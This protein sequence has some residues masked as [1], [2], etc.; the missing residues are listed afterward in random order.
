MKAGV[1]AEKF[2]PGVIHWMFLVSGLLGLFF[3]FLGFRGLNEPDEGRY[4]NIA[5]EMLEGEHS[6]LD[7]QMSDLGHYDKPPVIYWVAAGFFRI[8]GMNEW[9]ARLPS[10]LGAVCALIGLGWT[11]WRLYGNRCAWWSVLMAGTMVH[12]WVM[13]RMLTPDMLLAG[14]CS[15]AVGA[16]AETRHR[17]GAWGPWV[18]QLLFWTLGWWTK[19]SPMLIPLLGL[20]LYTCFWGGPRERQ[21][22]K[23]MILVPL[24]LVLG[25]PWFLYIVKIHPELKEF[26]LH[27]E[28]AGRITGHVDGRHG[29]VYFYFLTS[30]VSWLPWWP[31]ALVSAIARLRETGWRM[32]RL[33]KNGWVASPEVIIVVT[34]LLVFSLISSKLQTYTLTLAPWV[35]LV[36]ARVWLLRPVV[37]LRAVAV[38]AGSMVVLYTSASLMAPRMETSLGRNSS[39]K[40]VSRYLQSH[41]AVSVH[42]DRYWPGLEFYWDEDVTYHGVKAPMEIASDAGKQARHFESPPGWASEP[43]A[44]FIHF[45]KQ[46]G[47]PFRAWLDDP[48]VEKVQMG[49]FIVGRLAAPTR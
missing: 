31:L 4:A 27:R 18:A 9:A 20:G 37:S 15:L 16:W 8:F 25:S 41:G 32:P 43:D 45:R 39:L 28:M 3:L 2:E 12:I 19:A 11:A 13:A 29:P 47:S 44:W 35:A 23:L 49:D 24:I 48:E 10:V 46:E 33:R 5:Q 22:L 7:P 38:L 42:S 34:G 17:N 21:A 14:W 6:W 26:F 1:T 30:L 40:Q 36:F